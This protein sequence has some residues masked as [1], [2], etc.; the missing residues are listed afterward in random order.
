[1]EINF[2]KQVEHARWHQVAPGKESEFPRYGILLGK[3]GPSE[4]ERFQEMVLESYQQIVEAYG[5][6]LQMPEQVP[7]Y[8]EETAHQIYGSM[9]STYENIPEGS[10]LSFPQLVELHDFLAD[11]FARFSMAGKALIQERKL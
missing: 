4:P 10:T 9:L 3:H 7:A 1:M 8:L 11:K 6:S 5:K 2:Q